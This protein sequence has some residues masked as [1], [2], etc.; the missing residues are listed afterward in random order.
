MGGAAS[1]CHDTPGNAVAT[2]S[3]RGPTAG[4]PASTAPTPV[5]RPEDW[6]YEVRWELRNAI[7]Q[8]STRPSPDY[9]PAPSQVID[10]L[11]P[12]VGAIGV[13][14]GLDRLGGAFSPGSTDLGAA[15]VASALSRLG[16]KLRPGE[17]FD[18]DELAEGPGVI[19]RYRR[20]LDCLL[21]IL[22]ESGVVRRDG[23]TWHVVQ[24][25]EALDPWSEARSLAEDYPG[26][27]A[28]LRLHERCGTRLA[29]VLVGDCDPLSLLFSEDEESSAGAIYRDASTMKVGNLLAAE[30]LAALI[31]TRPPGRTLRI[32]ELG[33]G[34]GATT[35]AILPHV[36]PECCEYVFTDVSNL[37]LTRAEERFREYCFVRYRILNIEDDPHAQGFGA[38]QFDLILAFNVLHATRDLGETI[39]NVRRLLAPGGLLLLLEISSSRR[40]LDLTFGLT[41]GWWRFQDIGRR[42]THPLLGPDAWTA[43]LTEEGFSEAVALPLHDE[44]GGPLDQALIIARNA[45]AGQPPSPPATPTSQAPGIWLLLADERGVGRALADRLEARGDAWILATPGAEFRALDRS[46]Y[47][48]NPTDAGDY[49]RLLHE[50]QGGGRL[51][52]RTAIY[53]WG[54]DVGLAGDAD[55]L[56][57]AEDFACGAPCCWCRPCRQPGASP[58]KGSVV[59]DARAAGRWRGGRNRGGAGIPVGPGTG[60]R[61]GT[62]G[63]LGWPD[64]P[65]PVGNPDRGR[66]GPACRDRPT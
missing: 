30:A 43:L 39:A 10:G 49:C 29:D 12:R 51:P 37:F 36:P 28:V 53:L 19:P 35:A 25:P 61:A 40:W 1:R 7:E 24:A 59:G 65:G 23:S 62:A 13:A 60:H 44:A 11:R 50:A 26:L 3:R 52:L 31:A 48:I 57:R 17:E 5:R 47:Q 55:D 20:L 16:L 33:A 22:A 2:G 42:A 38:G 18:A 66:R 45:M 21:G 4:R 14:C 34:T 46:H 9:L 32:L 27:R 41:E 54:L 15:H 58:S 56:E 8:D 63:L 6:F 64:R